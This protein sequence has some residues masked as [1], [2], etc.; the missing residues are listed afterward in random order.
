MENCFFGLNEKKPHIQCKQMWWREE[1]NDIS[2]I[3]FYKCLLFSLIAS[4]VS[5]SRTAV[6]LCVAVMFCMCS[7]GLHYIFR[8]LFMHCWEFPFSQHD[9]ILTYSIPHCITHHFMLPIFLYI[10]SF[11]CLFFA[12]NNCIDINEC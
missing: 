7:V 11:S 9:F 5:H 6:I 2:I 10:F 3:L 1:K 12:S 4:K 8:F